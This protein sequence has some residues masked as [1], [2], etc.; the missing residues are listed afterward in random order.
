MKRQI[1][2]SGFSKSLL[3]VALGTSLGPY[4]IAF[5]K[6][7]DTKVERIAPLSLDD[8][9][10]AIEVQPGFEIELVASE[11]L[12][13][14]P[15]AMSFDASGALWVVEMVDYSEQEN[16][17]LGRLSK[18]T[19]TDSDGRMDRAEVIAEHLSW[20]TALATLNQRTWVA[21]APL[22]L[23]F[24]SGQPTSVPNGPWTS[25]PLL[26]GLG[27]QNVQG[28]ANSFRWGLDGRMHLS[29]SSNG[30]QLTTSPGSNLSL[31]SSPYGVSGRDIA[32]DLVSG[33][34]STVVGY[35][36][37]GM[38]FSPWGDRFVTSNSDHLQ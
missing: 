2:G 34:V 36:Q 38:D 24:R 37:H 18:L 26:E 10:A 9:R 12:I 17:A 16:D 7:S 22:V 8:V 1:L 23:E 15:V 21:A 30:G 28:L 13:Q 31:P 27:R 3:A 11:P 19:D 33:K 6:I 32:W 25:Q 5:Q 14:S 35:G 20:P 4:A 29:T